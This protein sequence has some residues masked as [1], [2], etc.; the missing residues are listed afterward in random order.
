MKH[1]QCLIC[2]KGLRITITQILEAERCWLG[3]IG[4]RVLGRLDWATPEFT[5]SVLREMVDLGLVIM[6]L[7]HPKAQ[8]HP[9]PI[10]L[11]S[12]L[13][14]PAESRKRGVS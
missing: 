9:I 5:R 8:R 4:I 13:T 6:M 11:L 3:E 10:Y 14:L 2:R 1:C 12:R 7:D